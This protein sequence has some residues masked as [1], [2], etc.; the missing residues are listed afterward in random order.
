MKCT[1]KTEYDCF[2][3]YKNNVEEF[4]EWINNKFTKV[5]NYIIYDDFLIMSF[6]DP[7]DSDEEI[8]DEELNNFKCYYNRWY[9]IKHGDLFDYDAE[10]FIK[11]YNLS[12]E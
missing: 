10:Y 6:E 2:F 11:Q 3:L 7:D 1:S 12:M 4:I 9:V 8:F 5:Y